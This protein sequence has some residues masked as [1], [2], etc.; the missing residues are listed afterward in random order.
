MDL[1]LIQEFS[2]LNAL[3][4]A[5]LQSL[6]QCF[7]LWVLYETIIVAAKN[8]SSKLKH[9]LS[10]VFVF[11]S[12]VWFIYTLISNLFI[13]PNNL[14]EAR[15]TTIDF[16]GN[17]IHDSLNQVAVFS[18]NA[19]AFLSIAYLFLLCL[20][21]V[22]LVNA[23]SQVQLITKKSLL[24]A[25]ISLQ[26]FADEVARKI[27]IPKKIKVWVSENI[28]V[29]ATIGFL[30][31]IILI[32]LSSINNLTTYQL[33]AIVL[34]EISHIKRN[35]YLVN[36]FISVIETILFFNPFVLL[37]V[38]SIK[39]ERENCCDDFV[40]LYRDDPHSYAAALLQ[41]EKFRNGNVELSLAAVS[42]KKQLFTRV[43]RIMGT[44]ANHRSNYLYRLFAL[45][46]ITLALCLLNLV[47]LSPEP[48]K[49]VVS[50]TYHTTSGL[51]WKPSTD[52]ILMISRK[53]KLEEKEKSGAVKKEQSTSLVENS[54]KKGLKTKEIGRN[55]SQI[56]SE[57]NF[58]LAGALR[59]EPLNTDPKIDYGIINDALQMAMKEIKNLD[60]EKVEN[61]I[62]NSLEEIRK[63][64]LFTNHLKLNEVLKNIPRVKIMNGATEALNQFSNMKGQKVLVDSLMI[65]DNIFLAKRATEFAASQSQRLQKLLEDQNLK[66]VLHLNADVKDAINSTR[67]KETLK[68]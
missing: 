29:P 56:K 19:V 25:P 62:N 41:L 35:D 8:I 17:L 24:S 15:F 11:A 2:F 44:T 7:L 21:I 53:K 6:W 58:S 4:I 9:N 48:E 33:E 37:M 13:I 26:S 45:I 39:R 1:R 57:M 38:K 40:L 5:I 65:A 64:N 42:D 63:Q 12:F 50:E 16:N 3:G 28:N 49:N 14:P 27:K 68:L 67:N 34:H 20:F 51:F 22:K 18:E 32:P 60:W 61:D 36:L 46:T 59:N 54:S 23:Y 10:V 52:N 30:K 47:T 31:P 66:M 55:L 43:K